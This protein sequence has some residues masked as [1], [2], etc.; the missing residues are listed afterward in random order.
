MSI[1]CLRVAGNAVSSRHDDV[2]S[3]YSIITS[4]LYENNG[5]IT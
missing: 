2:F 3:A 5:N 4:M 1:E